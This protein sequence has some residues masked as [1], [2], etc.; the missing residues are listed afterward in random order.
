MYTVNWGALVNLLKSYSVIIAGLVFMVGIVVYIEK[1]KAR[2]E[3]ERDE[4]D[5]WEADE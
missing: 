4:A 5:Y 2:K 1:E 3:E